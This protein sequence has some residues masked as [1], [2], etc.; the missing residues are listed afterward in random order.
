MKTLGKSIAIGTFTLIAFAMVA[1]QTRAEPPSFMTLGYLPGCTDRRSGAAAISADGRTI[2]GGQI[3]T[4]PVPWEYTYAG[5]RWRDGAMESL[6]QTYGGDPTAV[7]GASAVSSDGSVV[8]GY[9]RLTPTRFDGPT[10]T[11]IPS[12]PGDWGVYGATGASWDG[13][14]VVGYALPDAQDQLQAWISRNGV[15]V[16]LGYLF[17]NPG[18]TY[19]MANGVSGNGAAVVGRAMPDPANWPADWPVTGEAFVWRDGHM[20]GLGF[21]NTHAVPNP[22]D[23]THIMEI[24]STANAA[25]FDGCV[26]VGKSTSDFTS[27]FYTEAFRWQDG[28]MSSLGAI[29]GGAHA[30]EALAVSADGSTI[31]GWAHAPEGKSAFVWDADHGMHSLANILTQ[32]YGIEFGDW[33]PSIATGIS[34][35]GTVII[36]TA[37]NAVGEYQPFRAV[38]PEPAA[39]FLQVTALFWLPR[40]WRR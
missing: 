39:G 27:V 40:R 29:P 16:G 6:G 38:I 4:E 11:T 19:S 15:T 31:V 17:E 1:A 36:G 3:C 33:W 25:S 34:A 8:T 12:I 2:V 26:I 22:L 13:Q 24:T 18:Y 7:S 23:P 5:W 14:T 9:V 37:E 35:D 28:V 20:T 10:V 32:N 21:L 30:S